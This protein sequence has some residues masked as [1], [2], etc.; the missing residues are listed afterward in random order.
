LP[1]EKDRAGET[2]FKKGVAGNIYGF[3]SD[4]IV[5]HKE[6]FAAPAQIVQLLN[7]ANDLF[8]GFYAAFVPQ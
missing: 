8:T 7:F 1:E 2:G 6:Y 5:I 4:K 3:Y